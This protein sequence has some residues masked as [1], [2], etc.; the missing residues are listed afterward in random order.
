MVAV[1]VG[2]TLMVFAKVGSKLAPYAVAWKQ[3][4]RLFA[5]WQGYWD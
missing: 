5:V 2:A 1:S 4:E 3:E